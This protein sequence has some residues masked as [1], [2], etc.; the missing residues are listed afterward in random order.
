MSDLT[1]TYANLRGMGM[2]EL[3]QCAAEAE[4][5]V[6]RRTG[7]MLE[8]ID[9][10]KKLNY[11]GFLRICHEVKKEL[12]RGGVDGASSKVHTDEEERT[13]AATAAGS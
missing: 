3:E 5:L 6:V 12:A 13:G 4:C 7:E 1:R 2:D 11:P 10:I 9:S 8:L